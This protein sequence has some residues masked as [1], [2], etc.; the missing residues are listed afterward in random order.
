[1][2]Y[3]SI[4]IHVPFCVQRC[5]YCT[6]KSVKYNAALAAEYVGAIIKEIRERKDE[7]NGTMARIM[8]WCDNEWGYANRVLDMVK[9]CAYV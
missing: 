9:M 4:Y 7:I 1:M 8:A 3:S 5:T 6:F 2:K